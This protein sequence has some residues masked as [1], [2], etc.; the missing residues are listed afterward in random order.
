MKVKEFAKEYGTTVKEVLDKLKAFKLKAKD[1]NQEINR[2]VLT[3]LRSEFGKELK[4]K[5]RSKQPRREKPAPKVD[6]KSEIPLKQPKEEKKESRK[7]KKDTSEIAQDKVKEEKLV[8]EPTKTK[9]AKSSKA[10]KETKTEG[11]KV[12]TKQ[13]TGVPK[14]PLKTSEPK[15]T[16]KK[17]KI[18][19]APFVPVKPLSKR[20]KRPTKTD[21]T[22]SVEP[23]VSEHSPDATISQ[24]SL[25]ADTQE[26]PVTPLK[27]GDLKAIELKIPISVKD[28]AVAI[29]EKS[30]VV[31]KKLLSMGIF[32]NINQYLEQ[33]I[34]ERVAQDFGYSI[35]KIKTAEE[36][37][38]QEHKAEEKDPTY[39]K[40]RAPVVTFM[41]HVDHGKTSLLDQIRRSK[42]VDSEHGGITQHIGAY[43][44]EIDKGKI[45]FLDTPG[46]E[47]FTAM[48]AR[49]AHI[50]DL[51]VIV[52][53]ADEGIMPQTIEAIDHAR[54][55]KVPMVVALN[56]IDRRNADPDKVKKQL[57]EYDLTPEDWG[58]KTIVV[59][60]SALT[61]EGIDK[62]LELMLL[63]AELLELKANPDK[64][65]SGIVVEAH[66]SR[67]KGA[68]ASMIIQSGTL[69]Q[70][71][72]V[73]VGPYYGKIKAMFDDHQRPIESAGPSTPVEI[74]G[75]PAVPEAGEMFY[76]VEDEK[77]AK[78][79]MDRRQA[80]LK[81]EKLRSSKR[82][83]LEDLYSQIQEG[84]VKELNVVL[85]A[86]VQGS[87]EALQDSI[88]KIP[89][90]E[91]KVKFIHTGIG[92]INSS[93]VIL[94]Y[95]SNAIIIGFHVQTDSRAQEELE[96]QEVDVRHYRI[97]YDAVNDVRKALEGLLEP[98]K[99]R[100]FLARIEVRQVF[101][102]S[103][104][105][106]IAGCFVLKGRVPRKAQVDVIRDDETIYT[107]QISSLKRF[108]D[109]V[110]EVQE[111]YECGVALDRFT[112]YQAGDIFEAFELETI[113]RKL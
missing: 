109:D 111:G 28:F 51:V 110:R 78:E 77:R 103:K 83:T 32:A 70:G 35:T 89:S 14:S 21:K 71:D 74:L 43:S 63:E 8:K 95:A 61:G 22:S 37:L 4:Q 16:K 58:G 40:A 73:V 98:K 6:E 72:Y 3:V 108:K 85:K 36:Q 34:A 102:L 93:D 2:A 84:T 25:G 33:D 69:K 88:Q 9:S 29:G 57:S 19:S 75:L 18:S 45:T 112:D 41:G 55:A 52:V 44:V 31:L 15:L 47:A 1:G 81:D 13:E 50:T 60:V 20:R 59:P 80:Q 12:K 67:G 86:D 90:D 76:V 53:A 39:L 65:A 113:E 5:I 11:P 104:A 106:L 23:T 91:V 101:K 54:A 92:D 97:I 26:I 24:S 27:P 94:A 66:L 10:E 17:S 30:S 46:H 56:K 87:L 82:I 100:K 7:L 79:I 107:G 96:K 38:I 48:R 62:L 68:V 64:R 49:G 42:I 105:G 99:K